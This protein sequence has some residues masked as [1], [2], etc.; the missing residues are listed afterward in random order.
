MN[1]AETAAIVNA[2]NNSG[3]GGGQADPYAGYDVVIIIDN[4]VS[5]SIPEL[6]KGDYAQAVDKI[7]NGQPISAVWFGV[8]SI[9]YDNFNCFVSEL[10]YNDVDDQIVVSIYDVLFSTSFYVIWKSDNTIEWGD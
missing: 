9:N 10:A 1:I 7:T 6:V 5:G 8:N 4:G 2:L 3:G